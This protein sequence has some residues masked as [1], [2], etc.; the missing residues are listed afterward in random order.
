MTEM[1]IA[2]EAAVLLLPPLLMLAIDTGINSASDS[3][4]SRTRMP[5]LSPLFLRFE[6]DGKCVTREAANNACSRL[7]TLSED[8]EEVTGHVDRSARAKEQSTER[9][10]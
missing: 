3:G 4:T 9:S 1:S 8:E 7:L 10:N 2:D 6:L 5:P